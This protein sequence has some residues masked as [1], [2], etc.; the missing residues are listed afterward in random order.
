MSEYWEE[1]TKLVSL[2]VHHGTKLDDNGIDFYVTNDVTVPEFTVKG[3][4]DALRVRRAME[5]AAPK[6]EYKTNMT[7]ELGTL[8]WEYHESLRLAQKQGTPLR[9]M[10]FFIF[11]DGIWSGKADR[12]KVGQKI[13]AFV[14]RAFTILD[15]DLDNRAAS[16]QFIQ[17]GEDPEATETLRE[18]DDELSQKGIP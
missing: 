5:K 13:V 18:L 12:D 15:G 16:I 14:K 3:T 11:T 1:A 17:F 6:P 8:F 4:K 9:K 7:D 2:F 10:T